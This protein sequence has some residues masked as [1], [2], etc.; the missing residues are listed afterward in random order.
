MKTLKSYIVLFGII[1]LFSL[2]GSAQVLT[3]IDGAKVDVN[4]QAGKVVVLALGASWLPLSGKQ[5][6]YTAALANKY[7]G[8]NVVI[9]FI[10]TDSISAKSKNF[11]TD[12][13]IRKWA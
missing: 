6:E 9:Y 1:A 4:H 7:K 2:V 5:A 13:A 3:S 8:R 11:A 12:D 10:A